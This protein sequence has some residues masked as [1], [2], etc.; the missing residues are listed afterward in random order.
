MPEERANSASSWSSLTSSL[1]CGVSSDAGRCE[2]SMGDSNCCLSWL[3]EGGREE[4][5]G[6]EARVAAAEDVRV[7]WGGMSLGWMEPVRTWL[8]R[9][10]SGGE[11]GGMRGA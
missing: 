3:R 4:A 7:G 1:I 8:R 2:A 6:K 11:G 10:A 9:D 5:G